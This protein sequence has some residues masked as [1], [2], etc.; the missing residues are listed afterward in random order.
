[1]T[2]Y[3]LFRRGNY[4]FALLAGLVLGGSSSSSSN[5]RQEARRARLRRL[6]AWF[7]RESWMESALYFT[8]ACSGGG[9]ALCR[10]NAGGRR[11]TRRTHHVMTV[12][13]DATHGVRALVDEEFEKPEAWLF[14]ELSAV[15]ESEARAFFD[16]IAKH[17][18]GYNAAGYM[19]NFLPCGP[20]IGVQADNNWRSATRFFCS[21]MLTA[22]VQTHRYPMG[23][24]PCKTTPQ[25]L[26]VALLT[27]FP[28]LVSK[29]FVLN[30][31]PG[32][33]YALV[34]ARVQSV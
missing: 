11:L 2:V 32:D 20:S 3:A 34:A 21:E 31:G 33:K 23:L 9:C 15:R 10:V 14:V 22:F 19:Y 5:E 30:P 7:G 17:V 24:V 28:V 12:R 8:S 13:I 25:Q 16:Y 1:M 4:L 29:Q 18:T 26:L 6:A 27:S